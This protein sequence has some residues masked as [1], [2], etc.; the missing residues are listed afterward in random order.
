MAKSIERAETETV[1][2]RGASAGRIEAVLR[3][4]IVSGVWSPGA[5]LP[6]RLELVEKFKTTNVT[7]QRA[8]DRLRESEFVHA[9]R[10]GTFVVERPPHLA[11]YG[12][13]FRQSLHRSEYSHARHFEALQREAAQIESGGEKRFAIWTGIDGHEDNNEY[14]KLLA[15]VEAQ[16]YTGLIFADGIYELAMT[17]LAEIEIP[18]IAFTDE[19]LSFASRFVLDWD[20]FLT[21]S[22]DY[23][24]QRGRRNLAVISHREAN[25]EFNRRI[26]AAARKRN[27]K[28]EPFGMQFLPGNF[29]TSARALSHL[30]MKT[31]PRPDALLVTDDNLLEHVGAGLL[32]AGISVPHDVEIVAHCNLPWLTP[33][34]VSAKRIGFDVR[35]MLSR[36]IEAMDA[37]QQGQKL[38][39]EMRLQAVVAS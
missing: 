24:A 16:R 36:S 20:S 8:L 5:Q 22:L 4:E 31:S 12:L 23:L 26:E 32:E 18:R 13:V 7:V 27:L 19:D 21:L 17:P 28:I 2:E 14:Q 25:H 35:E 29:A 10:R 1:E 3:G 6:T 11:R 30:M 9:N 38:P 34:M 33:S 39:R 15:E 37:I